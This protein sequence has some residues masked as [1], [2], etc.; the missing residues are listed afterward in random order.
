MA[1]E[2][3]TNRVIGGSHRNRRRWG[4]G[5]VRGSFRVSVQVGHR[6][7]SISGCL[8]L[9]WHQTGWRGRSSWYTLVDCWFGWWLG[10]C[11]RWQFWCGSR[12]G[13]RGHRAIFTILAAAVGTM[14]VQAAAGTAAARRSGFACT[15]KMTSRNWCGC[16]DWSM[17]LGWRAKG[18]SVGRGNRRGVALDRRFVHAVF[19]GHCNQVINRAITAESFI[20][21]SEDPKA[22]NNSPDSSCFRHE[23]NANDCRWAVMSFRKDP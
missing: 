11:N 16:C 4:N 9:V 18:A 17:F 19:S 21:L 22:S 14:A 23:V 7:R 5:L 2:Y 1:L 12:F 6:V 3:S 8:D 13:V 10:S 20:E 15:A